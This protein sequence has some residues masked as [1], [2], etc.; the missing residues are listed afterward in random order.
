[1]SVQ[2]TSRMNKID[3]GTPSSAATSKYNEWEMIAQ[4]YVNIGQ[5]YIILQEY[6][7]SI[8]NLQRG[9]DT[10]EARKILFALDAG[11]DN[12][13]DAYSRLANFKKAFECQKRYIAIKDSMAVRN[14][15]KIFYTNHG[16]DDRPNSLSLFVLCLEE[17]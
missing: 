8:E 13:V 17:K 11:Y 15:K 5:T 14:E 2:S 7:R 1:M 4:T 3:V 6:H 16:F 10:L 9:I 12:L